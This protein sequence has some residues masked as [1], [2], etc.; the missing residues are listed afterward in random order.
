MLASLFN[1]VTL[2]EKM[3]ENAVL[4][5]SFS[6]AGGS[7]GIDF[8]TL[9]Q[10][11]EWKEMLHNIVKNEKMNPW[12]VD[13]EGLSL[14]FMDRIKEMKKVD[15]RVPANAI[16]A[17]SILLRFKSDAWTLKEELGILEPIY[18]PDAI[19]AEP[20]FPTLEPMLRVTKRKV[21]LDELIDAIED[22]IF[23]EKKQASEK[24]VVLNTIPQPLID[25]MKQ[26]GESF[27]KLLKDVKSRIESTADSDKMTTFSNL[28]RKRDADDVVENIVP[29][30]HLANKSEIDMWQ[31]KRF[32]E[33]FIQLHANGKAVVADNNGKAAAV[34]N[35]KVK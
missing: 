12:D 33:I 22:I 9:T 19:I 30:L 2:V 14:K 20:I 27:E 26:D 35:G 32:G 23:K 4:D 28:L 6:S 25:L 11:P 15:F 7:G 17:C 10:Q 8:V 5:S 29:V 18:I 16:L 31:D 34:G 3:P 13:I 21:N 24:R 1:S